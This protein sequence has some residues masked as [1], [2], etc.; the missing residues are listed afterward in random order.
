MNIE[1]EVKF[2]N[3]EKDDIRKRLK[4]IRA[5]LVRPEYFQKRVVFN[6]PKGYRKEHSWLRVRDEGDKITMA[7]KSITGE[8]G[9]ERQ[10]ELE[11]QISDFKIAKELL[12]SIGCEEKAYQET[13]R[14]LWMLG[15]VEITIDEWPFLLP[16]VEIEGKSEN[17]VKKISKK[18]GFNYSEGIFG[19]VDILYSNKYNVSPDKINNNTEKIVFNGK[20]PFL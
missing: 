8:K 10:K 1:Y 13:K 4:K 14:E 9:I 18:L 2:I 6:L 15:N 17:D 5:K 20:N 16:F 7:L 11:I 12:S 3:I 19:A